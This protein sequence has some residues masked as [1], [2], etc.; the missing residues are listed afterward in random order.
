MLKSFLKH[1]DKGAFGFVQFGQDF[2]HGAGLELSMSTTSVI[3]AIHQ[4]SCLGLDSAERTN[5]N[6]IEIIGLQ[7]V[8]ISAAQLSSLRYHH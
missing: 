8:F 1:L 5:Q 4:V 7:F 2:V 6:R 3:A